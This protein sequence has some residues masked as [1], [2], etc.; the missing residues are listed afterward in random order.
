M[1]TLNDK[2]SFL[3]SLGAIVMEKD[4]FRKKRKEGR[5]RKSSSRE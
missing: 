2:G 1:R 3:L 5:N 4:D